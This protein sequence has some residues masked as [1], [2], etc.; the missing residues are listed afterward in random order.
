MSPWRE[1]ER[2]RKI[3]TGRK[4]WN[5]GNCQSVGRGEGGKSFGSYKVSILKDASQEINLTVMS[6]QVTLS[7]SI[8]GN[9]M[10]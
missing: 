1:G 3:L 8:L 5:D 9:K 7:D 2:E 6:V 10:L 4:W